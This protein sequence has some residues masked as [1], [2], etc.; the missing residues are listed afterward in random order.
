METISGLLPTSTTWVIR[1]YVYFASLPSASTALLDLSDTNGPKVWFQQSDSKL[2]ARVGTTN[3]ASGQTVTTGQWYRIDAKFLIDTGGNDTADVQV[4]GTA[5]GLATAAGLAAAAS[6]FR[7]GSF[8][9]AT[10]DHYFDDLIVSNTAADYPFGAGYVN[11]FVPTADGAHNV[12]GASDF[13]FTITGTDITNATTTAYTLVDDVPLETGASVDWINMIAPPNA[14]DYVE[15][16]FGPAPGISTPTTG[17]RAVEVVAG[18]HQSAAG[19]TGNMEIRLNDNGTLDAMYTA[20]AVAGVTAVNYKRKHY[21]SAIAGGGE[22]VI[23]GG[24]NGDFSDL[25]VRFGSPAVVDANPD[26]YFD[27]AMIEAEFAEVVAAPPIPDRRYVLNH[28]GH[29]SRRW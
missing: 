16:I 25:R 6:A 5:C 23:G 29:R 22:W 19:T 9:A 15:C 8:D 14:T 10:V 26:Q 2:Y 1:L 13:E 27:C 3:G 17:P 12:A 24:G 18:I 11:H 7:I 4:N 21:A 28:S 20:T